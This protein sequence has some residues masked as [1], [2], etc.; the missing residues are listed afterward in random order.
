MSLK[1]G[2]E[3]LLGEP[4]YHMYEVFQ[5][6]EH[7]PMWHDAALG[8]PVDWDKLFE[9]YTSAV[10]W[11]VGAFWKEISAHYPDALIILSTR[12][13][14]KWWSSASET[15]FRAIGQIDPEHGDWHAMIDAMMENRFTK[16]LTNKDAAIAAYLKHNE[17]ARRTAPKSRFIEWTASDGWAPI[18]KA[19]NLPIPNEPFPHANSKEEFLERIKKR[20]EEKAAATS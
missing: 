11:P 18:C 5:H 10:D 15:I 7:V 3:K 4:C 8:K 14:E 17:D 12:D 9:G 13:A 16:D 20:E 1:Q 2:L 19:L 6:L